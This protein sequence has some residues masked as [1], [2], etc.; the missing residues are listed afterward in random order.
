M[1]IP[2]APAVP[3]RTWRYAFRTLGVKNFR[4]F[5][6]GQSLSLLGTWS[7]AIALA[8]LV[9]RLTQSA[10]WLGFVGFTSQIPVLFLGLVGGFVADR[11]PRLPLLITAQI[12]CMLQ[13]IILSILAYLGVVEL[14][15]IIALSIMLGVVYAFEFPL[16]QAFVMDM[17]GREHLLNAVALNSAMIHSTRIVGPVIAGFIIGVWGEATC[18]AV[19]AVSFIFLIVALFILDRAQLIK[20]DQNGATLMQA[21]REGLSYVWARPKVRAAL[22]T[23]MLIS[24]IG[25][26]YISLMPLFVGKIYGGTALSLGWLMS[27]SGVGA[28][29]GALYLARRHGAD[30][31][32]DLINRSAIAFSILVIVFAWLKSVYIA[33]VVLAVIAF[34][35]TILFSSASTFLQHE[36][37]NQLRG[38]MMSMFTVTFFGLSPIGSIAGGAVAEAVGAPITVAAS[39]AV[40][41]AA[42]LILYVHLK[43]HSRSVA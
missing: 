15:H 16:R 1:E 26:I 30:G 35:L 43:N 6:I 41:L 31:L 42:T 28:M 10:W 40:C 5:F 12:L 21:I 24:G 32:F 22:V 4:L 29:I 38:R 19:N 37:P 27:A 23:V 3:T 11:Y 14:W 34:F 9:W 2:A 7:Q 33:V 25:M 18:F 8:W 39:G 13:A 17:V 20:Q 36:V